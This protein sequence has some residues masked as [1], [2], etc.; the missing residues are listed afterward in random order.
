M[1]TYT[2]VQV[3]AITSSKLEF[4]R[5]NASGINLKG[6]KILFDDR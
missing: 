6:K 3:V 5:K 1:H 4:L 2:N